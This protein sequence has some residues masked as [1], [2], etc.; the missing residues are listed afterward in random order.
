MQDPLSEYLAA[1]DDE[2]NRTWNLLLGALSQRFGE[3]LGI[4]GILFLVGI[5]ESGRGFQPRLRKERKQD[6]IMHGTHCVMETI[7][8]YER[9]E[10]DENSDTLW[11][12]KVAFPELSVEKQEK[13]LRFA[14]IRYFSRRPGF[15]YL[16][17]PQGSS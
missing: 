3:N 8:I 2:V 12:R 15:E 7:G 13:L 9:V 16:T 10:D 4:E 14:I 1:D 5:Q 11:I 6:V 17:G